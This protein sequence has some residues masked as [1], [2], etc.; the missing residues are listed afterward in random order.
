MKTNLFGLSMLILLTLLCQLPAY[1]QQ[2]VYGIPDLQN[3]GPTDHGAGAQNW[4]MV[5]D[6]LGRMYFANRAGVVTFDGQYWNTIPLSNFNTARSLAIAEQGTIYVGG[7]GELGYLATDSLGGLGYVSLM[8]K[9]PEESRELVEDV[10]FTASTDE[11]IFFVGLF[12]LFQ[13]ADGEFTIY[14]MGEDNSVNRAWEIAGSLY[15]LR[16]K[17]GLYTFESDSVKLVPGGEAVLNPRSTASGLLPWGENELLYVAY[18]GDTWIFGPDGVRQEEDPVFENLRGI[19][20]Q[21]F[22]G[23]ITPIP[24]VGYGFNTF[25]RGSII[26]DESFRPLY[27]IDRKS[28]L[29]NN[30]VK[31]GHVD[32]AGN[33]WVVTNTGMSLVVL[34]SPFTYAGERQGID[35][36]VLS[37]V[38]KDDTLFLGT[39]WGVKYETAEGFEQ[40]PGSR[41]EIW[42]LDV[43]HGKL[44][45]SAGNWLEELS[46]NGD[47]R[48]VAINQPW[49]LAPLK[50]APGSYILHSANQNLM[51]IV[52]EGDQLVY[53]DRIMGYVGDAR[54][55]VEDS[56]GYLW[57]SNGQSPIVRLKL[58]IALDSVIE[59]RQFGLAEGLPSDTRSDVIGYKAAGDRGILVINDSSYYAW[60]AAEDTFLLYEPFEGLV[61]GYKHNTLKEAPDGTIYTKAG[62]NK[63][64]FLKT[65]TGYKLDTLGFGKIRDALVQNMVVMPDT[66]VIFLTGQ[67]IIQY[68]P[69]RAPDELKSFNTVISKAQSTE[70]VLKGSEDF[71]EAFLA[72]GLGLQYQNNSVRF[73]YSAVFFEE[74]EKTTFQY[75]LDGYDKEWSEWSTEDYKEYT[76][77]PEGT[78]TF[79][80]RSKNLYGVEGR[81]ATFSFSVFPP[82]YRS[83][84]AFGGYGMLALL[85]I[86]IIVRAYTHRLIKEKEKLELI[87]EERTQEIRQQKDEIAEQAAQLKTTNKKLVDLDRFKQDMTSMIAHDLKSPL[88]VIIK[89]GEKKT[90]SMARKMLNLV[91]NMLDVQKF[92]ETDV[93]PSLAEHSFNDL[94]NLAIEDVEDSI[95]EASLTLKVT[96]SGSYSVSLDP[97]LMERVLVNLLTNAVRYAPVGSTL[98]MELRKT[99]EGGLYF[100]LADQGPGISPE[101]QKVIFDR[102]AQGDEAAGGGSNSTGL[103]LTF[104]KMVIEAHGGEIGVE[105]VTGEGA[106][107]WFT[108]P[109]V[110]GMSKAV[111]IQVAPNIYQLNEEEKKQLSEVLPA[112]RKLKIYQSTEVEDTLARLDY[113]ENSSLAQFC[114]KLVNASYNGDDREFKRLLDDIGG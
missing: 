56:E 76:N 19:L 92:E 38:V 54:I 60:H 84:L 8:D 70:M 22:V 46:T 73:S 93:Q 64:R 107:F 81:E 9:I 18:T 45:A 110:S 39:A 78:Y 104:C 89:T 82:W 113:E 12:Y 91:L 75:V 43:A 74:P 65:A 69:D 86:W 108:L 4:D 77:L 16:P 24:G 26:T 28:G 35:T 37:A 55:L 101:K 50:K 11:G 53:R 27:S 95:A 61:G 52:T 48:E 68:H 90:A 85:V 2:K 13:Y 96:A 63:L 31:E 34:N 111:E 62:D 87:V 40:I 30:A 36:N 10:W 20:S 5:Q 59:S 23:K 114:Q 66:S 105:S 29:S 6:D 42:D 41:L 15:L 72:D 58:N 99:R 97:N 47:R 33:Y 103:G 3:F 98:Q 49:G 32:Q 17:V 67:G 100:S 83:G 102:Y 94:V 106:K 21:T 112:L 109:E 7:L 57:I 79:R 88:S 71:S 14:W 51:S 44:Y 80:V 1:G 25:D